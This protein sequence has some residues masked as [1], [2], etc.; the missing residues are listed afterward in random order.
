M[1]SCLE[2]RNTAY[3]LILF[4]DLDKYLDKFKTC[5]RVRPFGK[6]ILGADFFCR[7]H[8]K[9]L[10]NK[11]G[12]LAFQNIYNYQT[13]LETLKILKFR[14]PMALY[15]NFRPSPRNNGIYLITSSSSMNFTYN[16]SRKWNMIIKILSISDPVCSIKVGSFKRCVKACLMKIQ[17]MYDPQEWC[18]KNFELETAIQTKVREMY[19]NNYNFNFLLQ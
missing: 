18:D 15:S 3:N 6:Q 13:C 11:H 7:E 9:P 1:K 17:N 16:G 4:G 10:L 2:R 8:T 19:N 5:A 14:S 12:I